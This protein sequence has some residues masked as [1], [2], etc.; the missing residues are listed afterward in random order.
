MY[1]NSLL[2]VKKGLSYTDVLSLER[3][4]YGGT[5]KVNAFKDG[6]TIGLEIIKNEISKLIKDLKIY[7]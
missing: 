4:R 6:F 3:K 2:N 7:F 5:T 1:R